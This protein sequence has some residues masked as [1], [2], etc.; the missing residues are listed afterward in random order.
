MDDLRWM[1]VLNRQYSAQWIFIN[2]LIMEG[3]GTLGATFGKGGEIAYDDNR[4]L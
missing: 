1:P 4:P 3:G 2:A